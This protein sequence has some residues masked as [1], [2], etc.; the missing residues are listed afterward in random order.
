MLQELSFE[1]QTGRRGK[2]APEQLHGQG[3]A[4]DMAGR[5]GVEARVQDDPNYFRR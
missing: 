4:G 3:R 5:C 1:Q 2:V